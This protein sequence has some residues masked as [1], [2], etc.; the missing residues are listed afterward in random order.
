MTTW[1]AEASSDRALSLKASAETIE[2]FY[3]ISDAQNWVLGETL[4]WAL[5]AL[6]RELAGQGP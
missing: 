3:A 6:R 1:T 4:E 2:A 5:D